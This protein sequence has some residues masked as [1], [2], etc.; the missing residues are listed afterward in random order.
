MKCWSG[1]HHTVS[2]WIGPCGAKPRPALPNHVRSAFYQDITKHR[3]VIPHWCFGTTSQSQLQGPENPRESRAQQTSD[4]N[5]Y[6]G[7]LSILQFFK[8]TQSFGSQ[9]CFCF[10]AKKHLIRWTPSTELFSVTG[11]HKNSN[12]LRCVSDNRSSPR[13]VTGIWLL[14]A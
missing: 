11:H 6:F 14:K 13:V 3:V 1:P 9:L 4:K 8:D 5:F 10:Q 7:T 2:L 12:L